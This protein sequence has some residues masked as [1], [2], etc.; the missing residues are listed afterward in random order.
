MDESISWLYG[1]QE[2]A[3][4]EYKDKQKELFAI[5][6]GDTSEKTPDPLLQEALV[7][8]EAYQEAYRSPLVQEGSTILNPS[9]H[10]RRTE[11]A[12]SNSRLRQKR[13]HQMVH[14]SMPSP[15]AMAAAE[16]IADRIFLPA[17]HKNQQSKSSKRLTSKQ[18]AEVYIGYTHVTVAQLSQPST[19]CSCV[20]T[21][22]SEES[23]STYAAINAFAPSASSTTTASAPT[24]PPSEL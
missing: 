14:S 24:C 18:F 6:S 16:G 8:A 12:T 21:I 9:H 10:A 5:L 11:L 3:K 22:E 23:T 19:T 7:A 2:A 17:T 20:L 15:V 1:G 13:T 4:E